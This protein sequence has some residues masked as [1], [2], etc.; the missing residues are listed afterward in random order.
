M[1]EVV[2]E[3]NNFSY[4]HEGE[5]N[6]VDLVQTSLLQGGHVDDNHAPEDWNSVPAFAKLGMDTEVNV[7]EIEENQ[8]LIENT[9]QTLMI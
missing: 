9:K 2:K 5:A 7:I 4:D 6:F 1:I 3:A 8:E